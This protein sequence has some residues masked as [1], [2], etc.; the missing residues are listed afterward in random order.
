MPQD[1]D[2]EDIDESK[3][4]KKHKRSS[5][6]PDSSEASQEEDS[7][8][9]LNGYLLSGQELQAPTTFKSPKDEEDAESTPTA[10]SPSKKTAPRKSAY[11]S[12][13]PLDDESDDGFFTQPRDVVTSAETDS[14][15]WL[16][17]A[18]HNS[19]RLERYSACYETLAY[20]DLVGVIDDAV[21]AG[22]EEA[23]A[24]RLIAGG[25]LAEF[26]EE[27]R[28][29]ENH[30]TECYID[31]WKK[32]HPIKRYF[33][34]PALS[35]ER[36]L[37]SRDWIVRRMKSE[38]GLALEVSE[39]AYDAVNTVL[40][41][42]GIANSLIDLQYCAEGK[43][44]LDG[45]DSSLEG[46][47]FVPR[48]LEKHRESSFKDYVKDIKSWVHGVMDEEGLQHFPALCA[49]YCL[50]DAKL[51][52]LE[53]GSLRAYDSFAQSQASVDRLEGGKWKSYLKDKILIA[54]GSD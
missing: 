49:M 4:E 12:Q 19:D 10:P 18:I 29:K 20:S 21:G 23:I 31:L 3:E 27:Y 38:L 44:V 9:D 16:S 22:L 37:R 43:L 24:L 36:L 52:G 25:G 17:T 32:L 11:S 1:S 39:A 15:S 8:D 45:L 46:S 35:T 50:L 54:R 13:G 48:L 5:D 30:S 33:S 28:H 6:Y 34:Y 7:D 42:R 2:S 53:E 41:C 14:G 26:L 51:K 40:S 47:T